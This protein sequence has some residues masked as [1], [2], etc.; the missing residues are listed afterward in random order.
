[1]HYS[2]IT[3][4]L[5]DLTKKENPWH[6]TSI[7][8]QAFDILKRKFT[9][10]PVLRLPDPTSPFRLECDA[11]KFAYGAVLKQKDSNGMW[12][13]CGFISHSFTPTERNYEIYDREL[14]AIV[15]GLKAWRHY[16]AGSPF[17]VSVL[18]DHKNLTYF[19]QAQNLNRRQARWSLLLSEFNL[20]LHHTPGSQLIQADALSRR[21]DLSPS[22]DDN[23]DITLL[24]DNLFVNL[25]D[26]GLRTEIANHSDDFTSLL[27]SALHSK[28]SLP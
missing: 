9:T 3:R 5:H 11:S 8:Q 23:T 14:L 24:P 10:A 12:H 25:I 2:H 13:P 21:P 1:H 16:L 6:W 18:T 15:S 22:E 7:H 28:S 4:P 17:P 19:R 20:E 26:K 27:R